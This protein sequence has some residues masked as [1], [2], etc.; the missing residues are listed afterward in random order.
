MNVL[1]ED[2]LT[3]LHVATRHGHDKC[4]DSLLKAGT[5]INTPDKHG[6]TPLMS[7][8]FEGRENCLVLLL[9][10]MQLMDINDVDQRWTNGIT[11]GSWEWSC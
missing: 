11:K 1:S 5:D 3:P 10:A 9:T 7:A 2:D 4:V 6:I 8:A